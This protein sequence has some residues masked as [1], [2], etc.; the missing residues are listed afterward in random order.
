MLLHDN[1]RSHV[2][3][4]TQQTILTLGWE[5]LPHAAYS[6]D[7]A[8]S[9][10]HLFRSMQDALEGRRFLYLDDIR[11]FVDDFIASKPASFFRSGIRMLPDRWR[12][13]IENGGQYFED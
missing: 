4:A 8:P 5:V 13:V 3:R 2:G 7:I 11:K 12:K 9:D 1:A 10:C 6:P